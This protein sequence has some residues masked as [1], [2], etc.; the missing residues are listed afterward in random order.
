M[1]ERIELDVKNV[2]D[3][4]GSIAQIFSEHGYPAC[5]L[6]WTAIVYL[7]VC[8]WY[9]KGLSPEQM[10]QNMGSLLHIAMEMLERTLSTPDVKLVTF[11]VRKPS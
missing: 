3:R 6:T 1:P 10:G 5:P 4:A 7:M 9:G 8:D 2:F 11:D